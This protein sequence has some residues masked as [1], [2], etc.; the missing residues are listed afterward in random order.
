MVWLSLTAVAVGVAAA[1]WL[2]AK[3]SKRHYEVKAKKDLVRIRAEFARKLEQMQQIEQ[4]KAAQVQ[5][6]E[7]AD[8]VEDIR[9]EMDSLYSD[10]DTGD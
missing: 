5:A 9:H 7:E 8:S 10:F 6:I 4:K 1:S 3:I 2:T